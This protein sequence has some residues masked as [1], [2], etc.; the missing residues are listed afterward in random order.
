MSDN[1][2]FEK[3][4]DEVE[5]IELVKAEPEPEPVVKKGKHKK[6]MSDERKAQLRKQ[7]E[8][9]RAKS[10]ETRR[11]NAKKKQMAKLQKEDV[12]M[13]IAPEP[14]GAAPNPRFG[15]DV[16]VIK[17]PRKKNIRYVE[18]TE[19]EMETRIEKRIR[20]KMQ[21]EK[22]KEEKERARQKELD[23]LR[24]ENAMLKAQKEKKKEV[25]EQ[26]TQEIK[27]PIPQFSRFSTFGRHRRF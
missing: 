12:E 7:L 16:Q 5:E 14:Q 20:E 13:A 1:E 23:D 4:D 2:I 21:K 25:A 22:E 3:P 10:L 27:N 15:Q 18:E 26:V 19:E 9:A 24:N 11:A 6:P 17:Q 8:K